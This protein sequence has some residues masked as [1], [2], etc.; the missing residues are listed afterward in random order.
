MRFLSLLVKFVIEVDSDRS[1]NGSGFYVLTVSWPQAYGA[2]R[3]RLGRWWILD[4]ATVVL[5][6][7]NLSSALVCD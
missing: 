7:P 4:D 5:I 3:A 2:L 1:C 6:L